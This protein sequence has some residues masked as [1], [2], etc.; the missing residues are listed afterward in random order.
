MTGGTYFFNVTLRNR[1]SS[2]L[3]QH[4]DI[5]GGAIRST[6]QKRLFSIGAII[7]LPEYLHA[8]WSL[9]DRDADYAGRWRSIKRRFT[10]E[11]AR[12]GVINPRNLNEEYGVWQR[13]YREHTIRDGTDLSRHVDYIHFNPVNHGLDKRVSDW[14]CSSFHRH[15]ATGL[16]PSDWAGLDNVDDEGNYGE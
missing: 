2:L 5:L 10:P 6:L 15:V 8:I 3:T 4:I 7:I 9:P 13:R 12:A 1:R 16:Y 14:P 11:L